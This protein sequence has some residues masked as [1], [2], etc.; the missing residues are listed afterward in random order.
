MIFDKRNGMSHLE[1]VRISRDMATQ[2]MGRAGRLSEGVC[3]RMWAQSA[4][5][6]MQECRRP[7]ILDADLSS[8]VLDITA[9]GENDIENLPWLTLPPRGNV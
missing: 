6:G 7:E 9:W 2:R 4:E 8:L 5:H 3:Y 1:T